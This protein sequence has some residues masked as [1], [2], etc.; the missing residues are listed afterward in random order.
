MH[1]RKLVKVGPVPDVVRDN[2]RWPGKGLRNFRTMCCKTYT[3]KAWVKQ[4]EFTVEK[5]HRNS[6]EKRCYEDVSL[7]SLNRLM[8]V[9]F[10]AWS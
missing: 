6:L 8:C 10:S 4:S 9:H 2:L 5:R 3:R 7:Y 1:N